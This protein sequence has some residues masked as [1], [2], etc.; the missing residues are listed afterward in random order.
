[1]KIFRI[2]NSK[3]KNNLQFDKL[4]KKFNTSGVIIIENV[5]SKNKCNKFKLLLEL[6]QKKYA[7]LIYGQKKAQ[8]HSGL[9][10]AKVVTNLHNKDIRF[11]EFLDK[12]NI[13]KIAELLLQQGSYMN[14]DPIMCQAFTARS[15]TSGSDRQQIHN[16]ARMT[17]SKYPIVVQAMYVLDD[18]TKKNGATNFLLGSQK[19]L[20][21]PKNNHKYKNL[22]IAEAK[23]GSV[24]LFNGATWHGSSKPTG[25]FG[26]RWAIICR[27]SRWFFKPTFNFTQNTPT[28]IFKKMNNKQKDLLGFR[29]YPPLDEFTGNRSIQ[30]KHILPKDYKLPK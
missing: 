13:L 16:D 8:K 7:K 17:G 20:T 18:F 15:P 5:I 14:S 2:D 24:I 1:L 12:K 25:F 27:Y 30:K 6:Y 4:I 3:L 11:L 10:G 21:F 28:K 23:A 19:Y 26:N 22:V 29:Y 9:F